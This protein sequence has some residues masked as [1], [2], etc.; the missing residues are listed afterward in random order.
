VTEI[1]T[2]WSVLQAHTPSAE[3]LDAHGAVLTEVIDGWIDHACRAYL[4][5]CTVLD[6][7][8][9]RDA[10]ELECRHD[11]IAP[12][13]LAGR[14][15]SVVVSAT[16]TEVW[17]DAF[18]ISVRIRPRDGA[19]ERPLNVAC[20]IRLRDATGTPAALGNGIRDEL[21]ALEHSARHYN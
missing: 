10:L 14:P 2:K 13:A 18:A 16:A 1:S 11:A 17:P 19:S 4:A 5:Q 6:G 8:C 21:I 7:M 9:A 12:G 15:T 20:E 3:D